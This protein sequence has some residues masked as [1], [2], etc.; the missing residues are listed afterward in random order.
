MSR[1]GRLAAR[2]DAALEHGLAEAGDAVRRALQEAAPE[3]DPT[4]KAAPLR[5]VVTVAGAAAVGREFGRL[6]RPPAP[7]LGPAVAM[8]AG[9]LAARIGRRVAE[10]IERDA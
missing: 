2:V 1:W 4:V 5:V 7:V 8:V 9:T 6:D 3:L 10:E